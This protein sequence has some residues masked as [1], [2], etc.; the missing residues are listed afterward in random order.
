MGGRQTCLGPIYGD[1]FDHQAVV[2]EYEDGVRVFGFTR[3]QKECHNETSDFI[4]GTKGTCNLLDFAIRGENPWRFERRRES[5]YDLE[6]RALFDAVRSGRPINNGHYMCLSS[7]LAIMAQMACY[8]GN[9]V[10]WEEVMQS[11]RSLA[12]PRYDWDMEPPVR[13]DAN[14]HYATPMQGHAEFDRWE[15]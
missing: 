8:S 14:G 6:H 4:M 1:Q 11:K 2:F 9:L 12:L 5:M 3:D 15:M 13:P 10:T 7:G